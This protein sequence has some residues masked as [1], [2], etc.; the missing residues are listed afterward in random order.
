MSTLQTGEIT[1]PCAFSPSKE[2]HLRRKCKSNPDTG[3]ELGPAELRIGVEFKRYPQG[4]EALGRQGLLGGGALGR[5]GP[6]EA[7]S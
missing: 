5:R 6:W 4:I 7:E 2:R 1:Y 3:K